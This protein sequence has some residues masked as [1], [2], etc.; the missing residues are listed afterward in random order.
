M[1]HKWLA[2]YIE[3]TE[4]PKKESI[5]QIFIKFKLY[6][7]Y[8]Y[9]FIYAIKMCYL[10]HIFIFYVRSHSAAVENVW[11]FNLEYL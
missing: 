10:L 9:I 11:S 7:H 2:I 8:A 1:I 6:K 3:I 5:F 4:L